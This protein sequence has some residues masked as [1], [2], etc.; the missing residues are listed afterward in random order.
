MQAPIATKGEV[1]ESA[2]VI[3]TQSCLAACIFH[4]VFLLS[5]TMEGE[6]QCGVGKDGE[7][8][9]W[10]I[11]SKSRSVRKIRLLSLRIQGGG[12]FSL[13]KGEG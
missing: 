10:G 9:H 2:V 7:R 1:V 12:S 11:I 5:G 13:G 4:L 8:R 3:G 6:E